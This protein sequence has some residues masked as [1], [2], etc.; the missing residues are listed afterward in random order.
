[1]ADEIFSTK[2]CCTAEITNKYFSAEIPSVRICFRPKYFSD[3]IIFIFPTFLYSLDEAA[4]SAVQSP[5][6]LAFF[7]TDYRDIRMYRRF[8]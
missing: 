7:S 6:G 8:L 4:V 3:K 1:M 2:K 5:V